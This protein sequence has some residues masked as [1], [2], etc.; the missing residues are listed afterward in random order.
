MIKPKLGN[1]KSPVAYVSYVIGFVFS[2]L[3]TVLAYFLVVNN[4]WPKDVLIYAVL[5]IAVTQLVIQVVFFLHIGRGSHWKL[6]SFL[7]TVLIVAI[8][9]IG[10]VWIMNNLNY[11]MMDMSPDEMRIYMSEH[12]GI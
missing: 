12:E 7:F 2:V 1:R 11:N 10:S 9:V 5:L 8:V 6:V 4:V 3:A